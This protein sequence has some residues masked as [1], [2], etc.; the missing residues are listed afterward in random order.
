M[1]T[2]I[3]ENLNLGLFSAE[4]GLLRAKTADEIQTAF[5]PGCDFSSRCRNRGNLAIKGLADSHE[6]LFV[7]LDHGIEAILDRDPKLTV[8]FLQIGDISI[9]LRRQG[10][11]SFIGLRG[12]AI[13]P[14]DELS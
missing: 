10:A 6:L 1:T 7:C 12:K 9:E 8:P 14:L 13:S 3:D 11:E 2:L 5:H 4:L